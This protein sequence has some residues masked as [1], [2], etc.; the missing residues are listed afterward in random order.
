MNPK[1]I[2]IAGTVA[3]AITISAG[4]YG[5]DAS[6]NTLSV[7]IDKSGTLNNTK[8]TTP[9]S[10]NKETMVKSKITQVLG[11][12]SDEELYD[13]LY[14]GSSLADIAVNN[15]IAVQDIVDLQVAELTD[16]LNSRLESG[17]IT[18]ETY[19]SQKSE[20]PDI[21][22]KSIHVRMTP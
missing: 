19:K 3:M 22:T 18:P 17:S 1:R 13:A 4:M 15:H 20:L 8:E 10:S 16:Q 6:A 21:I 14:K 5:N 12:S 7:S 2:I 9:A 11:L